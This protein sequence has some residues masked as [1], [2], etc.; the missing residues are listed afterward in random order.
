MSLNLS[1]YEALMQDLSSLQNQSRAKYSISALTLGAP[2]ILSCCIVSLLSTLYTISEK[3]MTFV[4]SQEVVSFYCT[5]VLY[6]HLANGVCTRGQTTDVDVDASCIQWTDSSDWQAK[7]DFNLFMV[8]NGTSGAIKTNLASE[9][10]TIWPLILL[11]CQI[12]VGSAV[13]NL[14]ITAVSLDTDILYTWFKID[15]PDFLVLLLSCILTTGILCCVGY[16]AFLVQFRSEIVQAESWKNQSCDM[17]TDPTLGAYIFLVGGFLAFLSTFIS[18]VCLIRLYVILPYIKRRK[19][20]QDD[21]QDHDNKPGGVSKREDAVEAIGRDIEAASSNIPQPTQSDAKA[22][23]GGAN[24]SVDWSDDEE[25]SSSDET[26]ASFLRISDDDSD[27]DEPKEREIRLPGKAGKAKA[28]AGDLGSPISI[29]DSVEGNL[30]M[31]SPRTPSKPTPPSKPPRPK[32]NWNL[33]TQDRAKPSSQDRELEAVPYSPPSPIK[34]NEIESMVTPSS[35]A[36]L[37]N[38]GSTLADRTKDKPRKTPKKTSSVATGGSKGLESKEGEHQ[39]ANN[40]EDPDAEIARLRAAL[41]AAEASKKASNDVQ[42][43][44]AATE[45]KASRKT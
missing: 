11:L 3:R 33:A 34:K 19:A 10:E 39:K 25:K 15:D 24:A 31:D 35:R 12:A 40:L 17:N 36:Q 8:N 16:S 41:A 5:K 23:A 26:G 4:N 44:S 1:S 27:N 45:K 7:D 43:P 21:Q 13:G 42:S 2:V 37:P 29:L 28:A 30:K 38:S 22:A 14:L 9:A 18:V 32:K 6:V 20:V